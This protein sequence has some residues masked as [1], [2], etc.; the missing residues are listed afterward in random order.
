MNKRIPHLYS[1]ISNSINLYGVS[2]K[3]EAGTC[4]TEL[5][6]PSELISIDIAFQDTRC[7]YQINEEVL[8]H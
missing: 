2:G 6:G 3:C 1:H 7:K 4:T 8:L 5:K